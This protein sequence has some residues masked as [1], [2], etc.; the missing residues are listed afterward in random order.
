MVPCVM[1]A[2]LTSLSARSLSLPPHVQDRTCTGVFQGQLTSKRERE[3]GRGGREREGR[4]E[5][6][7]E[8]ERERERGEERE[9]ERER[10]KKKESYSLNRE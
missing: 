9:E 1:A 5:W 10:E 2:L 8:R 3:G 7:G 6:E 4:R